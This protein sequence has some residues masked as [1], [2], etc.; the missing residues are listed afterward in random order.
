MCV[1]FFIPSLGT[2]IYP[3]KK[4]SGTIE[5]CFFFFFKVGLMIAWQKMVFFLL[6]DQNPGLKIQKETSRWPG[7]MLPKETEILTSPNF[8]IDGWIRCV[9]WRQQTFGGIWFR[10]PFWP[11]ALVFQ[12]YL[13]VYICL[14]NLPGRPFYHNVSGRSWKI[15]LLCRISMN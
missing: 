3:L 6:G 12:L 5:D 8:L 4:K 14:P 13:H 11:D 10:I 15:K 9:F 7:I 2:K 1:W